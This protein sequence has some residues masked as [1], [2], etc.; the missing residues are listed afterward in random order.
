M[1]AGLTIR[2]ENLDA[3]RQRFGGIAR[4]S[5]APEDLGPEQRVDLELSLHE[6]TY[7]LERLCRYLE[8]CGTGN[9]SP[10]F[11]VRGVR[12]AG[13]AVV[14]Q[15]H[16]KGTLDDG[17]TGCRRSASSGRTGCPGSPT[18][19]WTPPSAWS[20]N[21]WNGQLSLQARLCA[22]GPQ[23]RGDGGDTGGASDRS[24][25]AGVT[26]DRCA[27]SPANSAGADSPCPRTPACVPPPT[28]CARHG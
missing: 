14:G 17:R 8:P 2:R 10:V 11:G 20:C 21:E 12:F 13:R 16:L 19:R 7:E 3:F 24:P 28:G 27:S 22:L 15:G 4:E 23:R 5:L 18:S 9:A 1:A 25:C 6:V 26:R